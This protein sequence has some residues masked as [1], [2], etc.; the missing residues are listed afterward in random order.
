MQDPSIVIHDGR[1]VLAGNSTD[2]GT[3]VSLH[4]DPKLNAKGMLDLRID[5]VLFGG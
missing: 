2:F 4:F 3:V 1:I 5:R